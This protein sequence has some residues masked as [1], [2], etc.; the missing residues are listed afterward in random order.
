MATYPGITSEAFQH[1]LDREAENT[2]RSVPGFDLVARK[3]VEFL[4]ERPQIISLKGSSIQAGPRQFHHLRH[5]PRM[6]LRS[7]YFP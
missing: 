3:F 4:Y 2:L 6:Y 7:R 5:L 1:P